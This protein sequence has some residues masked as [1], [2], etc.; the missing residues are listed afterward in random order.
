MPWLWVWSSLFFPFCKNPWPFGSWMTVKVNCN[1]K[2]FTSINRKRYRSEP[3]WDHQSGRGN[4]KSRTTYAVLFPFFFD[5]S[6]KCGQTDINNCSILVKKCGEKRKQM[7]KSRR[8]TEI[9]L[10]RVRKKKKTPYERAKLG[11]KKKKGWVGFTHEISYAI[12][13]LP[14]WS[15]MGNNRPVRSYP[16]A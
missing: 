9:T 2:L 6:N 14:T 7:L 5:F 12:L 10:Q 13:L 11:V 16:T 8:N 1:H 15:R 4:V 3:E